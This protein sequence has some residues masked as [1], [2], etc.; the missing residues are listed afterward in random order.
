MKLPEGARAELIEGEI[1]MSPSPKAKHQRIVENVFVF[2]RSFVE[3]RGLGVVHIAPLDVHLTSGEVVQPDVLFVAR[4]NQSIIRDWI[5]GVPDLL[6]EVISPEGADRDLF[7]KREVYERN[8]VPEYW[9]VDGEARS[10]EVLTLKSGR[11]EP[12]GHFEEKDSV[13]S[14][15]LAGLALPVRE[16]LK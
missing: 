8:G 7:T 9:I 15:V 10:V 12:H 4:A 6:I 13:T 3:A 5:R 11:F 14:L 16:I 1:L 2:L